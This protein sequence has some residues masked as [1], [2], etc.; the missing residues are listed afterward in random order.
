MKRTLSIILALILTLGMVPL[1]LFSVSAAELATVTDVVVNMNENAVPKAGEGIRPSG[2]YNLFTVS[3]GRPYYVSKV[4]QWYNDVKCDDPGFSYSAYTPI[5]DGVS[6]AKFEA[7]RTYHIV[8]VL[9]VSDK[10]KYKF[11]KNAIHSITISNLDKSQYTVTDYRNDSG[12][13]GLRIEFAF[14]VAGERKYNDITNLDFYETHR[15]A[16]DTAP[17]FPL[18]P[19][20]DQPEIVL[21]SGNFSCNYQYYHP[22]NEGVW[23]STATG[24]ESS[25]FAAGVAYLKH[26]VLT[27]YDGYKFAEV[28]DLNITFHH[29]DFTPSKVELSKDRKTLTVDYTFLCEDYDYVTEIEF[30]TDLSASQFFSLPVGS[31]RLN[32]AGDAPYQRYDYTSTG[33][34]KD[35]N[36][37]VSG[38]VGKG[39]VYTFFYELRTKDPRRVRFGNDVHLS[40]KGIPEDKVFW[41][42]TTMNYDV[43]NNVSIL[44]VRG[45]IIANSLNVDYGQSSEYPVRCNSFEGLK[46]ALERPEIK[47]VLF[48]GGTFE[49]LL[50][51]VE[52][53]S[54]EPKNQQIDAITVVGEK[55][56]Y[57]HYGNATFIAPVVDP[58]AYYQYKN[59][60]G[61]PSDAS[62]TI[63]TKGNAYGSLIY[64]GNIADSSATN[65]A[66]ANYGTTVIGGN[67][68]IGASPAPNVADIGVKIKSYA[69][70]NKCGY[71]TINGG[72]FVGSNATDKPMGA[73]S[74]SGGS[75]V[76]NGG[77]FR[78]DAVQG[79]VDY[80]YGLQIGLSSDVI[81]DGGTYYNY[82]IKMPGTTGR[83]S[84]YC[85]SNTHLLVYG[86]PLPG[87][88]QSIGTTGQN[89]FDTNTD[90][91]SRIVRILKEADVSIGIPAV[92]QEL[93]VYPVVQQEGVTVTDIKWYWSNDGSEWHQI[94]YP[95]EYDAVNGQSYKVEMILRGDTEQGVN[96][97]SAAATTVRLNGKKVT[98]SSVAGYSRN[99]VKI[100]CEYPVAANYLSDVR[101]YTYS[102]SKHTYAEHS[103][104]R[105]L[106]TDGSDTYI[107]NKVTWYCNGEVMSAYDTFEQG[108]EYEVEFHLAGKNGYKFAF[109]GDKPVN[110]YVMV[111]D[112]WYCELSK[113]V[114]SPGNTNYV[115]ARCKFDVLN[116]TV[117]EEIDLN[118]A[119]PGAGE[120]P[121]YDVFQFDTRLVID[122]SYYA[123]GGYDLAGKAGFEYRRYYTKNCVTW[124][125]HTENDRLVYE[126][127]VLQPG[128]VYEIY[129]RNIQITDTDLYTYYGS[130]KYCSESL[131][132]A[133]FNGQ[134]ATADPATSNPMW[135]HGVSYYYT[136]AEGVISTIEATVTPPYAGKSAS[137][138][139]ATVASND[140]TVS[141]VTWY[142]DQY[143]TNQVTGDFV[144]GNVYDVEIVFD[145]NTADGAD[146]I[147]SGTAVIL[148]G[149]LTDRV[150]VTNNR[151]TAR[152]AFISEDAP[153]YL[154]G[155]LDNNGEVND[156]DAIYLLMYTFFPDEYP[157]TQPVDYDHNGEITDDD[158]IWLLMYTFFA[159]EYPIA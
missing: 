151:V 85:D 96:F 6:C 129:V 63:E 153:A 76:V 80:N 117:V 20:S 19:S 15:E 2:E 158:A 14:K 146:R 62:L 70:V 108:N 59:L 121:V 118:V 103:T 57:L 32:V 116:D 56:L 86:T 69:V 112:M 40:I 48:E 9:T 58:I 72:T 1:G 54:G 5:F 49:E 10:K 47:Y 101:V 89:W 65:A 73:V 81:L 94:T 132:T 107:V 82:G 74:V 18:K 39:Y 141:S 133:T 23:I 75:T 91:P 115:C 29:F 120:N 43:Y 98:A 27:A 92:N 12:V 88:A 119:L 143:G 55:T 46:W 77:V 26:F 67:V 7:G 79:A 37:G 53:P 113:S 68:T 33:T 138:T 131:V 102:G 52:I 134:A 104:A 140:Y 109:E 93:D 137:E 124:Y 105:T 122:S 154:P 22:D 135:N 16:G 17:Y 114:Y 36:P 150:T 90:R 147:F 125:D 30:E 78:T 100:S 83:L 45:Y 136:C 155:D 123:G 127:E 110:L 11:D 3:E 130:D 97:G 148:N 157:V 4:T 44:E 126:D 38:V 35:V 156:D 139:G 152:W 13:S 95:N 28:K 149:Q 145:I 61:V 50:P 128:H 42:T 21:T 41:E 60:I 84:T 51:L 159:D 66:I 24:K 142:R 106:Y 71:L 34:W 64:E 111:D 25:S 8:V 99:A 87:I 144:G 31:P